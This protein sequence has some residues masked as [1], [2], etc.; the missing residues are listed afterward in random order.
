M[1]T[2]VGNKHYDSTQGGLYRYNISDQVWENMYQSDFDDEVNKT[3]YSERDKSRCLF[4]GDL[5]FV[6]SRWDIND[7]KSID[8]FRYVN[9]TDPEL[10]WQLYVEVPGS[11]RDSFS[12]CQKND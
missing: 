7:Y 2:G 8:D 11:G 1:V 9:L 5:L 10:N 3:T 4:L 6:I 12:F